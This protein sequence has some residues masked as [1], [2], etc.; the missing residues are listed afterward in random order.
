MSMVK[1][2]KWSFLF[3]VFLSR[4]VAVVTVPL[5][6]GEDNMNYSTALQVVKW[7]PADL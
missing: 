3:S 2:T 4:C 7:P 6:G 1:S 5:Q